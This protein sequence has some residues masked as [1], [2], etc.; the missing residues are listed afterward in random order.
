[1]ETQI[2]LSDKE[3][4]KIVNFNNNHSIANLVRKGIWSV[5]GEAGYDKGHPLDKDSRLVVKGDEDL[6]E[7]S[8]ENCLGWVEELQE[9][10]DEKM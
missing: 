1:M 9:E 2:T 3:D 8:V 10:I 6:I 7:E 4:R 5:G